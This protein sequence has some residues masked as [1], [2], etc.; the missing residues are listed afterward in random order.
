MTLSVDILRSE[1]TALQRRLETASH[2]VGVVLPGSAD[3][4]STARGEIDALQRQLVQPTEDILNAADALMLLGEKVR[5]GVT[6]AAAGPL[7]DEIVEH[8][9]AVL[10]SCSFQD[11]TNQRTM[12][13][14]RLIED[15]AAGLGRI[16][17][18]LDGEA[19]VSAGTAPRD[20]EPLLA[21]PADPAAA[22]R[23]SDVDH[24]FGGRGTP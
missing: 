22:P 5:P 13:I 6:A 2:E 1:V 14:V 8:A 3:A 15:V 24:L 11:L 18:A 9:N 10:A 4:L 20:P 17:R 19:D 7:A 16:R 23:Q 21:G 12:K